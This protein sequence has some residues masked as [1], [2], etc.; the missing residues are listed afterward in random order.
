[1]EAPVLA[2]AYTQNLLVSGSQDGQVMLWNAATGA[3]EKKIAAHRGPVNA[4]AL[5]PDGNLVASAGA[6]HL[7]KV[8]NLATGKEEAVFSGH[9]ADVTT[10]A[11]SKSGE[12]LVSGAADK[13]LKV[14]HVQNKALYKTLLGHTNWVRSVALHPDGEHIASSGDDKRV[15]IW[16]LSG[17]EAVGPVD[18]YKRLHNNWITSVDYQDGGLYFISTGHDNSLSISRSDSPANSYYFR[19]TNPVIDHAGNTYAWKAA[20]QPNSY[21][22]AIATLGKGVLLTDYFKKIFD[23]PHELV[24]TDVDKQ[25]YSGKQLEFTTSRRRVRIKGEVSRPKMVSKMMLTHGGE[26]VEIDV[27]RSGKFAVTVDL[28]AN[29]SDLNFVI[30][31]KDG[32]INQSAHYIKIQY[33]E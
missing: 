16:K 17:V 7:V 23:I 27:K 28:V 15:L 20:F 4:L 33:T 13:L 12:Y 32:Q 9:T 25:R 8:W 22:I 29:G 1:H 2:L 26:P 24:I 5:S 10:V 3:L 30:M 21:R 19:Y 18:E 31:D 6:D 14:W 11:F